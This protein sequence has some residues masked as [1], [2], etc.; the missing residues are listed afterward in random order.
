MTGKLPTFHILN[1]SALINE[2]L[3]YQLLLLCQNINH[4]GQ[5]CSGN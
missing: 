4:T 3:Y 2:F 5:E 1:N